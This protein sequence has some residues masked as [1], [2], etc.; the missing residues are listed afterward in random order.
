[1]TKQAQEVQKAYLRGFC[2]V[3]NAYGVDPEALLKYAQAPILPAAGTALRS[4]LGRIAAKGNR[5][6]ELLKGGNKDLQAFKG[7]W[8]AK[9]EALN[10]QY[11]GFAAKGESG[12]KDWLTKKDLLK[13]E[14]LGKYT[15]EL[16]N[17]ALKVLGARA[18]AGAAGLV[19]ASA[20]LSGGNNNRYPYAPYPR[21]YSYGY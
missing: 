18:G 7:N 12:I 15:P 11:E 14:M 9:R 6:L 21:R 13:Q 3:A 4:L 17:E 20:L 8:A 2:K 19:G 10:K 1:M 5:F 16:Q